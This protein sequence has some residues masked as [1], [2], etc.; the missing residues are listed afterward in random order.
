MTRMPGLDLA[1]AIAILWVMVFHSRGVGLLPQNPVS[2]YGWMGVDL[3]FV[4]SGFLICGQLL[5]AVGQGE[6][7][8]MAG[9][10]A[11]RAFRIL[12]VYALVAGLYLMVPPLRELPAIQPAWQFATF[13]E[14]LFFDESVGKA[15][16]HVWSLC[17]EEHFY[18]A[19]PLIAALAVWPR[20]RRFGWPLL[21]VLVV[22]G[23]A[24]RAG[25]WLRLPHEGAATGHYVPGYLREIYY[26]TWCRLDGLLAG[27]AL[28][29][30]RVFHPQAWAAVLQR[31]WLCLT[32][33]AGGMALSFWLFRARFSLEATTL[34]FPVLAAS[35]AALVAG[36][37]SPRL[38][39]RHPAWGAAGFVAA[40]SYSLYLCHKAIF[41][42]VQTFSGLHG[43]PLTVAAWIAA[44][45]AGTMLYLG[46][47]R[48]FLRLRG[49]VL[50]GRTGAVMAGA[51][52]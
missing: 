12:P 15:F 18:L 41:H 39:M 21:A 10:Y 9:F 14:N 31:P 3:F 17:V 6:R 38:G 20:A 32:F 5:Q 51:A 1:R 49:R 11:R 34:G 42:L 50:G 33:A 8:L 23:V 43:G 45:A 4:L 30:V 7:P 28:A 16:S 52:A 46:V 40:I 37:A 29:A 19:A 36:L 13:T 26:P 25:L 35:L 24:L 44:L 47:E 22:G 2:N 27:A 48:P